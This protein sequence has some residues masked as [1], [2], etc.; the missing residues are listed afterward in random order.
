MPPLATLDLTAAP[1][2]LLGLQVLQHLS[3]GVVSASLRRGVC[4]IFH[5]WILTLEH[6]ARGRAAGASASWGGAA[7][8][9]HLL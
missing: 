3:H 4:S 6:T 8:G 7:G 5:P 2:V 1:V 9:R